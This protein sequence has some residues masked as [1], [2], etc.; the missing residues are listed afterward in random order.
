[1]SLGEGCSAEAEVSGEGTMDEI[2]ISPLCPPGEHEAFRNMHLTLG[3]DGRASIV[4]GG[5]VCVK[6]V[7]RDP[8]IPGSGNVRTLCT[9]PLCLPSIPGGPTLTPFVL[10]MA[11][12][13]FLSELKP[14]PPCCAEWSPAPSL[15]QLRSGTTHT[16]VLGFEGL[17]E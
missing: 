5:T 10:S 4:M 2:S 15:P 9:Q 16:Q 3:F 14:S 12:I 6:S 11:V 17:Y 7:C 1:M 13:C 8:P